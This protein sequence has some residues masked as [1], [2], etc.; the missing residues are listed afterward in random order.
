MCVCVCALLNSFPPRHRR[1]VTLLAHRAVMT[2]RKSPQ[3]FDGG[4]QSNRRALWQVAARRTTKKEKPN[5]NL[6][7]ALLAPFALIVDGC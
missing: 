6:R 3:S 4:G 2:N 7:K 5:I 1:G